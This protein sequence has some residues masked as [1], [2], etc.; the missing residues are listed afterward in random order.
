MKIASH[1]LLFGESNY[2]LILK[3]IQNSY[4]FVDK[5]YIAYSEIPW[6]YRPENRELFKTKLDL[7]IIT[8]SIY[9][10]KVEIINGIW[11]KEE[12][13]RNACLDK[14]KE[15]GM[16]YLLIH[17]SDEFYFYKD[18]EKIINFIKT[19]PNFSVYKCP[20]ISF[21]K[22]LNYIMIKEDGEKIMG[23]P[24]IALNLNKNI[25]F[26]N[27]RSLR[28]ENYVI[29]EDVLNY[30]LSYVLSDE[31]VY[32]KINVWGHSHQ[33]DT[34]KWYENKWLTWNESLTGLHP[35]QPNAWFKAVRYEGKLPEVLINI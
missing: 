29:I 33:F 11:N 35:I 5:I 22:N 3:N 32:K 19:Y 30:H 24:E 17:D 16:D 18:F 26:T 7:S 13:Q 12:E 6:N 8:D 27:C 14:A 31:E 21:W 2:N 34:Q 20:W 4:N 23:Y 25:R 15:D 28:D 9:F 10:D 1:V